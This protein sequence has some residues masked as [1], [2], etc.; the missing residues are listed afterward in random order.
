MNI[1]KSLKVKYRNFTG[2]TR[3]GQVTNLSDAAKQRYF[4]NFEP[5]LDRASSGPHWLSDERIARLVA[6]SLHF[7]DGKRYELLCYCIMPNHVHMVIDL[8]G[9]AKL[10]A[11]GQFNK[12]SYQLSPILHSIKRYTARE[13]N[14][15]LQRTGAF[16]QHESYDHVVRDNRELKR[17]VAYVLHNPVQAGFVEDWIQWQ[18]SYVHRDFV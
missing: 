6:D 12:L 16:W 10:S 14:K 8:E 13:G 1:V 3:V 11:V 15:L 4:A 7:W 2:P 9:F 17:I 18:G 5:Y